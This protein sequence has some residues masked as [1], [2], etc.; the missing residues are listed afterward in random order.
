MQLHDIDF[1][2][3][4]KRVVESLY[5]T[6]I[7]SSDFGTAIVN[8]RLLLV[9]NMVNSHIKF[10]KRKANKVTHTLARVAPS[11]ASFHSFSDI[12]TCIYSNIMNEMR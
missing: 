9:T 5:S 8:C 1:E 7:Y 11:F 2:M 12:P 10:I 3:N 6:K 4:C